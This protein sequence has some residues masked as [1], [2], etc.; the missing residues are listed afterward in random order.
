MLPVGADVEMYR[1]LHIMYERNRRKKRTMDQARDL[2]LLAHDNSHRRYLHCRVTERTESIENREFEYSVRK[3][4]EP[5]KLLR[6]IDYVREIKIT[7]QMID[8]IHDEGLSQLC[9][10][11]TQ[12][13][14]LCRTLHNRIDMQ[15]SLKSQSVLKRILW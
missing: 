5:N 15:R 1:Y 11:I 7:A 4:Q 12:D 2:R 9:F 10:V 13:E 3:T 8:Y 14:N 6:M